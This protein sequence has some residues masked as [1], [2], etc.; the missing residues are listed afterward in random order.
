MR[1][2]IFPILILTLFLTSCGTLEV[3]LTNSR[4]LAPAAAP[5]S[6]EPGPAPLSMYSTSAEIRQRLLE[7]PANWQTIFID[8]QVTSPTD[9]PRR[10]QVWVDQPN[11]SVRS[12][13]G[14][15][16]GA[17]S[18][19]RVTDGMSLLYL[20]ILTGESKLVPFLDPSMNV[21]YTPAPINIRPGE[22]QSHPLFSAPDPAMSSL[23]FPSDIA[24]NEGT[25]KPVG[26]DVIA[27]HLVLIVDWT[28]IQNDLPSYRA[29]VDVSTGVFLRFQQFDKGGSTDVTSEVTVMRVDY[30]LPFPSSFFSPTVTLMPSFVAEPLEMANVVVTPAAPKGTDPLGRV[31]V[32]LADNSYPVRVMRLVSLPASCVV[33]AADCPE[34]EVIPTPVELTSSLQPL[35]WSS[36]RAEAAWTYP[37]NSDQRI[38][39]LYLFDAVAKKWRELV[40]MERYM[41]PPMWSRSGEWIAFRTQDGQGG[42]AIYAI[43]RD[44]SD[45][46]NL[47]DSKDLP[48]EGRPYVMDSWL[49][50]N[51]VLRSAKPGGTGTLYLMRV[52]DGF[53]KPL[54][55]TSLTK[56][57]FIES[58]DGTLLAYVDYDYASQR[59]LVKILTPDGQTLRDLATFANGSVM[60][61]AWSPNGAQLGFSHHT[62]TASS[63]YVIDSDGRN[64]QQV[65][66]SITDSQFVFSPDGKYLLVQTID[67]TGE[68]L[69]AIDLATLQ[70]FLVQAPGIP[71]NESWMLP[72]WVR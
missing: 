15:P 37:V 35:V 70:P 13:S 6:P 33:G 16:N 1:R 34:A 69:Y 30:N 52:G 8:A 7:S 22:I 58:P 48:A 23:L 28:Y 53:V 63:V 38:W 61:L 4:D 54:F 62:D 41:D 59:Q 72:T 36:A 67:G 44:G 26:M 17:A 2:F 18:D 31:Y 5:A 56:A 32:F 40:Q 71:L 21:P 57:P 50:E 55:E 9:S 65:Y 51:V 11:L 43:R 3:T 60:A 49:G 12:L 64:L 10:V 39:T 29:W 46:K 42:E 27:Y 45:L 24:Q 14:D 68:H 20:N 25:F 47:T 66:T 19:L